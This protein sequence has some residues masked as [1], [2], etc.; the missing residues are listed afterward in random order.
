MKF[1]TSTGFKI[2]IIALTFLIGITGIFMPTAPKPK[3]GALGD[4]VYQ[5]STFAT[6]GIPVVQTDGSIGTDADLTFNGT[7][8][9][10]N[11]NYID[12]PTG[13]TAT[14]VVAASDAPTHVKAQSDFICDGVADEVQ[15]NEAIGLLTDGGCVRLVGTFNI[16]ATIVP[17]SNV[18]LLAYHDA[19]VSASSNM[20]YMVTANGSTTQINNFNIDGVMF[21]G[22]SKTI[23]A[24][25]YLDD[26]SNCIVQNCNFGESTGKSSTIIGILANDLH[27]DENFHAGIYNC[28]FDH[29]LN[30]IKTATSDNTRFVWIDSCNIQYAYQDGIYLGSSDGSGNVKITD[31]VINNSAYAYAGA[32]T[33]LY[34]GITITTI[35]ATI[36]DCW[37]A[38]GSGYG[39]KTSTGG[40]SAMITNCRLYY[41]QS[42]GIWIAGNSTVNASL[43]NG[44]DFSGNGANTAD[45]GYS[46]NIMLYNSRV[47]VSNNIL[48]SSA[49]QSSPSNIFMFTSNTGFYQIYN[50]TIFTT[51]YASVVANMGAYKPSVS[52][53]SNEGYIAPGE[54]R[55]YSGTISALVQDDFN[56]LDNPF[57]Q[58]VRV[59]SLQVY[60]STAATAT[61][62]NIDCGV[63]SSAT[64]DYATLFDDL[65]G[66]TIGFYLSTVA[67]P[68]TQTVPILW[69]YGSGNR[70]L[71]FSIKDAAAT[72][73]V[74]TYT[75]TVMGN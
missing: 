16:A 56:S 63:G 29:C 8:L 39:V 12:S 72:G 61:T 55:T 44:C 11:G 45:S 34:G 49:S 42:V 21:D 17:I 30:G 54:I 31:C 69:S 70:Y 3:Y 73:M 15:I 51:Y 23:T 14:Y 4:N 50:N 66:E 27:F 6:A 2:I 59:V 37:I 5:S 41:N 47:Q 9:D 19:T 65:P 67:T 71:N 43:I 28:F 48:G 10:T 7:T 25:V 18:T 20:T 46:T 57:G 38:H 22:N 58:A 75:V 68:G 62:P 52:W 74:A 60:V 53:N 33:H 64:T 32:P 36:R 24:M 40:G 26:V 13:R 1:L 35:R